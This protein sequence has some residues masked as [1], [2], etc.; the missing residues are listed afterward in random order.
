M[1]NNN[2]NKIGGQSVRDSFISG[3]GIIDYLLSQSFEIDT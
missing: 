3:N 2:N 1:A